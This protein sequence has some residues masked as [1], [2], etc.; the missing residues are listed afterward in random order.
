MGDLDHI[1]SY[2]END[3]VSVVNC[4]QQRGRNSNW[5]ITL[6][7]ESSVFVKTFVGERSEARFHASSVAASNFKLPMPDVVHIDSSMLTLYFEPLSPETVYGLDFSEEYDRKSARHMQAVGESLARLHLVSE[8]PKGLEPRTIN[9]SGMFDAIPHALY[10]KLT[11]GQIEAIRIIH[12]DQELRSALIRAADYAASSGESTVHGDC[13]LD[14]F[15]FDGATAF[16]TDLETIRPGNM[17]VDIAGILGSLLHEAVSGTPIDPRLDV[18]GKASVVQ[19]EVMSIGNMRIQ[20]AIRAFT[21]FLQSYRAVRA[22]HGIHTE[23][24]LTM[25]VRLSGL[26]MFDRL[27]ANAESSTVLSAAFLGAAGVGKSLVLNPDIA[28]SLIANESSQVHE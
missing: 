6:N 12:M 4:V 26:Y 24:D 7:D 27:L 1:L 10:S 8:V 9:M 16:I 22:R 28:L 13:R 20:D 19:D 17:E 5:L 14:Q 15:A 2:L 25:V 23:I 11:G 18:F 21:D 3:K